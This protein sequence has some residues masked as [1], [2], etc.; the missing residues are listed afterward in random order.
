ML[1]FLE[2]S[3]FVCAALE[4]FA[5]SLPLA[6]DIATGI[7]GSSIPDQ[8]VDIPSPEIAVSLLDSNQ[9]VLNASLIPGNFDAEWQQGPRKLNGKSTY[10]NVLK[11]MVLLSEKDFL[12]SYAGN[13]FSF[14]GYTEMRIE[15]SRA[16]ARSASL[17]Y[18]FVIYGLYSS[19]Y[20]IAQ[21]SA[22]CET[23]VTLY[24]SGSG[25]KVNVGYIRFLPTSVPSIGNNNE[26][27]SLPE[28]LATSGGAL[29]IPQSTNLTLISQDPDPSASANAEQL[30]IAPVFGG[31]K[32]TLPEV[33][34]TMFS[35]LVLI[36]TQ[37]S[38]ENVVPFRASEAQIG[39]SL[40]LENSNP[41]R[42][43]NPFFTYR[44][45]AR[46]LGLLPSIMFQ[47]GKFQDMW[48]LIKIDGVVVGG[49]AL[50]KRT[51]SS[52]EFGDIRIS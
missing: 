14:E 24:W 33:F 45:A 7:G 10:M 43:W 46:S 35:A 39:A 51:V 37:T 1:L 3:L 6:T 12:A 17:Q 2:L 31:A 23:I 9:N 27:S 21:Q 42:A 47:Q 44:T 18:R 41:P 8:S 52:A 36:S 11:A 38:T 29:A 5:F 32:L 26:T 30:T 4:S 25:S 48:F 34:L 40:G 20:H 49:G 19:I 50:E 16:N 15:V 28:A 13:T 22:W